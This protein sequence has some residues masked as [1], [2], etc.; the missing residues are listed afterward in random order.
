MNSNIRDE[1]GPSHSELVFITINISEEVDQDDF[2][3]ETKKLLIDFKKK[4]LNFCFLME[5][6][7]SDKKANVQNHHDDDTLSDVDDV[8]LVNNEED[9]F[10]H[11]DQHEDE[12]SDDEKEDETLE[13]QVLNVEI[14]SSDN[15]NEE[16]IY[17]HEDRSANVGSTA[18]NTGPGD[19]ILKK[20][21]STFASEDIDALK[22]VAEEKKKSTDDYFRRTLLLSKM[23]FRYTESSYY[24]T[25][26]KVLKNHNL[27]SLFDN[28]EKFYVTQKGDIRLTFPTRRECIHMLLQ[29]KRILQHDYRRGVKISVEIM[30]PRAELKKKMR[31]KSL[32][33]R[34]KEQGKI[35][36]YDVVQTKEQG[37]FVLK[38][39]IYKRGVGYR[40][41][42]EA[43][44]ERA[45][46]N[47]EEFLP[48]NEE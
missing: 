9:I 44:I 5:K 20:I 2:T 15:V 31:L 47:I 43:E 23:E 37:N 35:H 32:G 8:Q 26:I 21:T 36:S 12:K 40:V 3:E 34:G 19:E 38:L 11:R 46:E 6:M 39:R 1:D 27:I 41:L 18:H 28:C 13:P 29:A 24:K 45:V 16:N 10:D 48:N 30:C 14:A 17:N 22:K 4:A 33:R 42:N 7:M 25:C